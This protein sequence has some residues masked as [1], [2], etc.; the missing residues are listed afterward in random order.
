[1]L[2]HALTIVSTGSTISCYF[3]HMLIENVALFYYNFLFRITQI[4][5]NIQIADLEEQCSATTMQCHNAVISTLH[6]VKSGKAALH[7]HNDWP[8]PE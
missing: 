1:M 6:G 3:I 8:A 2:T 4:T 5:K 7:E